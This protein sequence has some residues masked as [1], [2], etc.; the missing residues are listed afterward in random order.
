MSDK[1]FSNVEMFLKDLVGKPIKN[2]QVEIQAAGKT[3]HKA[4]TDAQGKINFAVKTGEDVAVSVKHWVKDEMKQ[5]ATFYSGL[6]DMKVQ[7]RSPKF[8]Q[9]ILTKVEGAVGQYWQG[10]YTVKGGDTL[11]RIAKK[12]KVSVDA[13]VSC[14][15]LKNKNVIKVGQKLKIPATDNRKKEAPPPAAPPKPVEVKPDTNVNGNPTTTVVKGNAPVIFPLKE[16]P[17]NDTGQKNDWS[18][19]NTQANAA[20]YGKL[21]SRVKSDG[22]TKRAHAGRDLYTR[23]TAPKDAKP[24][25][26]VVA[27]APGKILIVKPFYGKTDQISIRHKTS[28]GREFIVRYGEL[29][30]VSIKLKKGESVEQGQILGKTGV[31]H[32]S[33][34]NVLELP[35]C[36]GKNASMLHFEYFTGKGESLDTADDLS[37]DENQYAR[38]SDIADPLQIL[39]E[40]Y[41]AT[42]LD[43]SVVAPTTGD[44]NCFIDQ[45]EFFKQYARYYSLN[46]AQRENL[47]KMIK[48]LGVYYSLANRQCVKEQVAYMLATTKHETADTFAPISEYGSKSYFEGMYD[49]FLA[50]N[51]GRKKVAKS[52]GNTQAG[53]GYNFRGRGFVQLTGR[54]NYQKAGQKFGIALTSNPD[55]AKGDFNLATKIMCWGMEE[56]IFTGKKL[57]H[58]INSGKADYTNARKIIN[59]L[60]KAEKIA[61]YAKNIEKCIVIMNCKNKG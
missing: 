61:S 13:L 27:I 15:N 41:K 24:G 28:D 40:G 11:G 50:K 49:L 48:Q 7:L 25:G 46:S 53:D 8:V 58:Y 20:V 12:Y 19:P 52:L 60:D 43:G 38:R 26:E 47:G 45:E 36:G 32:N 23:I 2:L 6:P 4:M 33:K 59:G 29:D 44:C 10:T 21:G 9:E 30:P 51:E 16:R 56:G 39:M 54:A 42:F 35:Q 57:S 37:A 14:N 22:K 17:L 5:V 34:G 3:Y 1:S 18:N 31:L 55:L